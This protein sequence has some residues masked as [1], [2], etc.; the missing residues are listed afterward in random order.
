MGQHEAKHKFHFSHV[1]Y[2]FLC[3]ISRC[4]LSRNLDSSL[5]TAAHFLWPDDDVNDERADADADAAAA[6]TDFDGPSNL[7]CNCLCADQRQRPCFLAG[8]RVFCKHFSVALI[9]AVPKCF[10]CG[11]R[12]SQKDAEMLPDKSTLLAHFMLAVSLSR[13]PSLTVSF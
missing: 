7:R 4:A 5:A 9:T 6:A 10:K 1:A 11:L 2:P 12:L 8:Q 3:C 13:T